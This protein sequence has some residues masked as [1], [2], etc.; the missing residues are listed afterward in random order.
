MSHS[1]SFENELAG[2]ISAGK[3]DAQDDQSSQEYEN[4]PSKISVYMEFSQ[5]EL[6]SRMLANASKLDKPSDTDWHMKSC[7]PL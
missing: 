2:M 6:V 7:E 5:Q 4:K 1:N 3:S